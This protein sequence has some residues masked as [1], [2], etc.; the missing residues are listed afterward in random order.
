MR[1]LRKLP[2][3]T[4]PSTWP[5]QIQTDPPI[6]KP[7]WVRHDPAG[8]RS[9][10][11]TYV[12]H[13]K[14]WEDEARIPAVGARLATDMNHDLENGDLLFETVTV[15]NVKI[16]PEEI[17]SQRPWTSDV[18]FAR[19]GR[20]EPEP[21]TLSSLKQAAPDNVSWT[22][23]VLDFNLFPAIKDVPIQY[24]SNLML[25]S[26]QPWFF[27]FAG[28]EVGTFHTNDLEDPGPSADH[29]LFVRP[30]CLLRLPAFH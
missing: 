8:Y 10:L 7:A 25:V 28:S 27:A 1:S 3:S 14:Q 11:E 24:A 4:G 26:G 20:K 19:Y 29:L 17:L 12:A 21:G 13:V 9:D 5:D 6:K 30:I 23:F 18:T 15:P 16:G 2:L 22:M